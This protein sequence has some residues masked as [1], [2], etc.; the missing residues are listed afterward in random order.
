MIFRPQNDRVHLL[1]PM[2]TFCVGLHPQLVSFVH[3]NKSAKSQRAYV[4][5]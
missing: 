3:E 2:L 4:T 1:R 5:A